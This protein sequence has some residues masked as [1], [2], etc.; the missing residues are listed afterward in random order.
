MHLCEATVVILVT[1]YGHLAV[2]PPALQDIHYITPAV[3]LQPHAITAVTPVTDLMHLAVIRQVVSPVALVELIPAATAVAEAVPVV[4]LVQI[5][6]RIQV[7]EAHQ[8][9][10]QATQDHQIPDPAVQILAPEPV[11]HLLNLA[12]NAK[13]TAPLPHAA[14]EYVLS[15][16][17]KIPAPEKV[18]RVPKVV[19]TDARLP[20]PKQIAVPVSAPN[21]TQILVPEKLVLLPRTVHTAARLP[22]QQPHVVQ[23]FVPNVKKLLVPKRAM[24][25]TSPVLVN[26]HGT[27]TLFLAVW[28]A[29][30]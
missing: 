19:L 28:I 7:A 17:Q 25:M 26:V 8:T 21:V 24:V 3:V 11:V 18:V 4:Q 15:A 16:K 20:A 1:D 14:K 5:L 9:A 29:M 6:N 30:A 23:A 13:I 22:V 12:Q 27:P 10:D 2:I